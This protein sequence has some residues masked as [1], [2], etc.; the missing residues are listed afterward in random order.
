MIKC[1]PEYFLFSSSFSFS[2]EKTIQRCATSL[3]LS[4]SLFRYMAYLL[5]QF[6]FCSFFYSNKIVRSRRVCPIRK[7]F[8]FFFFFSFSSCNRIRR[9]GRG[10]ERSF[11]FCSNLQFVLLR[12]FLYYFP[13]ADV[14][15]FSG[16]LFLQ[17]AVWFSGTV[18]A[19]R[20]SFTNSMCLVQKEK[21]A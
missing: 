8:W 4:L 7:A 14:L 21:L 19:E 17:Q 3:S 2:F 13:S 16:G 15:F 9:R 18:K 5:R 11:F 20:R 6:F 12:S 1:W 10:R